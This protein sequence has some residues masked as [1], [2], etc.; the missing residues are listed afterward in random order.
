MKD[1]KKTKPDKAKEK[2]REKSAGKDE[3]K[4][5]FGFIKLWSKKLDKP[6]EEIR[7]MFDAIK[8]K[9]EVLHP[10]DEKVLLETTRRR[11]FNE[12]KSEM[13]SSAR[14]FV[15]VVMSNPTPFDWGNRDYEMCMDKYHTNEKRA[16]T[17][18]YVTVK[19]DKTQ[20]VIGVVPIDYW[21]KKAKEEARA[22]EANEEPDYSKIKSREIPEHAFIKTVGGLFM[23][24]EA[25][26]KQDWSKL[27][28][29]EITVSG[30][31]ADPGSPKYLRPEKGVT[32]KLKLT[33]RTPKD[34]EGL[35]LLNTT[36]LTKLETVEEGID[37]SPDEIRQYYDALYCPLGELSE[38][39]ESDMAT[40]DDGSKEFGQKLVMTEGD[41][42]DIQLSDDPKQSHRIYIDDESIGMGPED[43]DDLLMSTLCWFPGDE[44]IPFGKNSRIQVFGKTSRA[45]KKDQDTGELTDEWGDITIG[46]SGY[47][48]V[49][50]VEPDVD[51]EN[52]TEAKSKVKAKKP[53]KKKEPE[54]EQEEEQEETEEVKEEE[55]EE[56]PEDAEE[57][58]EELEE[59]PKNAKGIVKKLEKKPEKKL[60][61]KTVIDEKKKPVKPAKKP[62]KKE[63]EDETEEPES[64][65]EDKSDDW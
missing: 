5:D 10:W 65:G 54:E 12:F 30:A 45:L 16:I 44:P 7:Q 51:D 32:Y 20:K 24:R 31:Q 50:L 33:N 36:T 46:A 59:K 35:W 26:D 39:H 11:L 56:E 2:L 1:D 40:S 43:S 18:R 53:A 64:E 48:I 19:R 63:D 27:H 28:P 47:N 17:E 25:F 6:Q 41:V 4:F 13:R 15:G 38:F 42:I 37:L 57:E 52:A 34:E 14:Y 22:K 29:A 55:T 61:K 49:D 58:D 8:E 60:V 3:K 62:A 9:L 21:K 23:P